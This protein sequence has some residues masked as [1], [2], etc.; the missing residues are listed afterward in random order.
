MAGG[1]GANHWD[2]LRVRSKQRQFRDA[3]FGVDG[4]QSK[5][6]SIATLQHVARASRRRITERRRR[7]VTLDQ[8]AVLQRD[9]DDR[10]VR[11]ARRPL[12]L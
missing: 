11:G 9:F 4:D 12:S 8:L 2:S 1:A 10:A 5:G 3:T 7:G 6:P